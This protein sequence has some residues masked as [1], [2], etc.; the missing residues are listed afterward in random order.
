MF[1]LFTRASRSG[2]ACSLSISLIRSHLDFFSASL[3]L[4]LFCHPLLFL[5]RCLSVVVC[6]HFLNDGACPTPAR[7]TSPSLV[8]QLYPRL[9][10]FD[11]W[12]IPLVSHSYA[13]LGFQ[14]GR[15][16]R[17]VRLSWIGCKGHDGRISGCEA[18]YDR[19]LRPCSVTIGINSSSALSAKN[20]G[21]VACWST[22]AR[23]F[24][25]D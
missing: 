24:S 19:A 18:S 4:S 15:E 9:R 11:P 3:P 23:N 20:L 10:S 5:S 12:F 13:F 21:Q 25:E 1:C 6:L 16:L 14:S 8:H 7:P 22:I 17:G 2:L